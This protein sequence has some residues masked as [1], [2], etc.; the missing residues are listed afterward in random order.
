M[1]R[2]P[3][4]AAGELAAEGDWSVCGA[5]GHRAATVFVTELDWLQGQQ[6]L[7][8]DRLQWVADRVAAGD[9]PIQAA[10]PP[11]VLKP[12]PAFT[13]QQLLLVSGGLLLVS[14]AAVFLAVNWQGL[15]VAAQVASVLA[16]IAATAGASH[17][18]R[19]RSPQTASTLAAVAAGILGVALAAAPWLFATDP[20]SGT[21]DRPAW[22]TVAGLLTAGASAV[23]WRRTGD[24]GYGVASLAALASASIAEAVWLERHLTDTGTLVAATV[25]TTL[26][27]VLAGRL[28]RRAWW[29]AGGGA[30][31]PAVLAGVLLTAAYVEHT[32]PATVAVLLVGVAAVTLAATRSDPESPD[33]RLVAP[34]GFASAGVG[35]LPGPRT[36]VVV[37]LL[38]AAC[39]LVAV[40]ARRNLVLALVA[41][42][43]AAI[44]ALAVYLLTDPAAGDIA[45][46]FAAAAVGT[47][48]LALMP[49]L[50]L[51]APLAAVC[52]WIAE[53]A[54]VE[55]QGWELTAELLGILASIPAFL[56]AAA[57]SAATRSALPSLPLW[58][59]GLALLVL[60]S[61]LAAGGS[62]HMAARTVGV[63]AVCAALAAVGVRLRLAAPIL[64]SAVA[65]AIVALQQAST[66]VDLLPRWISLLLAGAAL[67]A[68]GLRI[69]QLRALGAAGRAAFTTLR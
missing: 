32:M 56:A 43:P 26:L 30:L 10:T 38:L 41:A 49:L 13:G 40:L 46:V 59:P 36:A 67:L 44:G 24:R 50:R 45:V 20:F 3:A 34:A 65:A 57:W 63:L 48:A 14:A 12:A 54:L 68:A 35:A 22:Y 51:A 47:L 64:V 66:L 1:A 7:V 55:A 61:A 58:G 31:G 52:G 5:C 11:P 4:C 23:A 69:E 62:E 17:A 15:G 19:S 29:P 33:R 6:R 16:A 2:C 8:A 39:G 9:P 60:P 37:G 28:G 53:A 21:F 42:A 27:A 25:Q 18:L